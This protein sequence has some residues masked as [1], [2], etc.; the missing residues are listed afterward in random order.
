MIVRLGDLLLPFSSPL[1]QL[2]AQPQRDAGRV[3]RFSNYRN[4]IATQGIEICLVSEFG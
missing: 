1:W 3:H 2:G 4:Q